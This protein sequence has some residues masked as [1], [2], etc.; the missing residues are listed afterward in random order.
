MEFFKRICILK[1]FKPQLDDNYKKVKTHLNEKFENGNYQ[2]EVTNEAYN[3]IHT[4]FGEKINKC[5]SI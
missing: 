5:C 2:Y 3:D 1:I 4:A